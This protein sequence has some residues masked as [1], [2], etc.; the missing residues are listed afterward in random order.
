L[1]ILVYADDETRDER[2][3]ARSP[4]LVN[5][6]PEEVA[7]RLDDRA[8]SD[9][10]KAHILIRNHDRF[11]DTAKATAETI[12]DAIKKIKIEYE[13]YMKALD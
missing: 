8:I 6:K 3:H 9:F 7:M 13:Y 5:Q 1:V 12:L 11:E 2:L 10:P 4:D